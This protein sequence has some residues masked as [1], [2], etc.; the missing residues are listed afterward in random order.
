MFEGAMELVRRGGVAMPALLFF[1]GWG[2]IN[3]LI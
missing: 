2:A 3:M 1:C